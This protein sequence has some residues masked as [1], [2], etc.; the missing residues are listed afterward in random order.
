VDWRLDVQQAVELP[1]VVATGA[2]T[3]LEAG[4]ALET[5]RPGLEARGHRVVGHALTSGLHAI[6]ANDGRA[7]GPTGLFARH[8]GAGRWAGGADPRREGLAR[9]SAG[10]A[11]GRADP[12][13]RRRDTDA[14]RPAMGIAAGWS[15][16]P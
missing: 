6:V 12:A 15:S 1:N 11:D 16:V 14:G 9:G 8:P 2:T 4:T 7:D 13:P 5:L 3:R 10:V